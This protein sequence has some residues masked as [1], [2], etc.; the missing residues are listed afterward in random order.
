MVCFFLVPSLYLIS[1]I[2]H[3]FPHKSHCLLICCVYSSRLIY[4]DYIHQHFIYL[5]K[6]FSFLLILYL[7]SVLGLQTLRSLWI[8]HLSRLLSQV[9]FLC[10][11]NYFVVNGRHLKFP[12]HHFLF[13]LFFLPFFFFFLLFTHYK[14]VFL[15]YSAVILKL[16]I[17]LCMLNLFS[18]VRLFVTLWAVAHQAL[19]VHG[20]LPGKN[21]GVG[22]LALLLGI[23]P[24]QKS[25]LCLLC[26]LHCRRILYPL[27]HLGGAILSFCKCSR[28]FLW[29]NAFY[30]LSCVVVILVSVWPD[31]QIE[32]RI[33]W[34]GL[35]WLLIPLKF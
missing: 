27:N 6:A 34:V 5:L 2:I 22:C 19:L 3:F 31:K 14:I 18:R 25:N 17:V 26:L 8:S 7:T 28:Q 33:D 12:Q 9:S 1:L 4:L 35:I 10:Y 29:P 23:L 30:F 13:F 16:F 20:I 11:L 21:T 15:S 32:G 24:T